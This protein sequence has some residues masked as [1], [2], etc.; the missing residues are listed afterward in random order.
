MAGN[1][2]D[3]KEYKV[4]KGAAFYILIVTALLYMVNNMDR[5]VLAAVVEPM[6]A[7]LSLNDS[8]TIF[9]SHILFD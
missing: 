2:G 8:D 9:I 1:S 3:S 7:A 4:G 6:K 5:Q